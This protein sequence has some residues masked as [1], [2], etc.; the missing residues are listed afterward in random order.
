MLS[1]P[2]SLWPIHWPR[3]NGTWYS[4]LSGTLSGRHFLDLKHSSSRISHL[5]HFAYL[6][7][8][9]Y[10]DFKSR[11]LGEKFFHPLGWVSWIMNASN[12]PTPKV[13]ILGCNCTFVNFFSSKAY[14]TMKGLFYSLYLRSFGAFNRSKSIYSKS[15]HYW[16]NCYFDKSRSWLFIIPGYFFPDI[17]TNS[18]PLA[19]VHVPL[20]DI[21]NVNWLSC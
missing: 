2:L 11:S 17:L 6:I 12:N 7:S 13:F 18:F 10:S 8:V 20:L 14:F 15:K 19:I 3:L 16:S 5:S 1:Q 4:Y 9:H 21:H